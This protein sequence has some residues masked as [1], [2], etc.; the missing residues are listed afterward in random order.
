MTSQKLMDVGAERAVLAGLFQH[1][2]EAYVEINDIID[3]STFGDRNNQS[4]FRC[5]EKSLVDGS[6]VDIQSILSAAGHLGLTEVITTDQGMEYITSLQDFPVHKDNMIRYSGQIKKYELARRIK[7][8]CEMAVDKVE[9]MRGDESLDDV[10]NFIEKPV[11]DFLREGD[12]GG[13]IEKLWEGIEEYLEDLVEDPKDQIGIASGFPRWDAVIG[14]GLRRGAVDVI[15]A[16]PKAGKS[17]CADNIAAY[18]TSLG[19]PVLMLDS[20]MSKD[21]HIHRVLANRSG[22]HINDIITGKFG[23]DENK[24]RT[25][26]DAAKKELAQNKYYYAAIAGETFHNVINFVKRWVTTEV[27]VD[28]E[29]NTNDCL[30]IYDYLKMTSADGTDRL[31]EFQI[32]GLQINE[33]K[34]LASKMDFPC[35]MFAQ[36]N[37]E[38]ETVESTTAVGGSDRIIHNCT[39]FSILKPKSDEEQA[40]DGP[41]MGNRKLVPIIARHGPAME[42]GNYINMELKGE[43]A[44]LKEINTR[45]EMLRDNL[46]AGAIE[47][48][49]E[50]VEYDDELE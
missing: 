48:A 32:L 18:V 50:P 44:L 35:V 13:K 16:R 40:H 28:E 24:Y 25:V 10:I 23:Q 20:E 19:I 43:Y 41:L 29:G 8:I 31:A 37:R 15:S 45:D 11:S 5:I 46:Y 36:L 2:L 22:V 34:T 49:T 4:V 26:F 38:G 1:G 30:V 47:G 14:G 6:A 9:Q 27:G 7:R 17:N 39:S 42:G 33:M 12:I 3:Y 21:E